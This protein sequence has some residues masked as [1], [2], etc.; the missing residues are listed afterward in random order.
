MK[1]KTSK[2]Q[3]NTPLVRIKRVEIIFVHSKLSASQLGPCY[4]GRK[5]L[6]ANTGGGKA[7]PRAHGEVKF[8]A[9]G[10]NSV[11]DIA[12]LPEPSCL[13]PSANAKLLI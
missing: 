8:A 6:P 12:F 13:Y 10:R 1:A 7:D 2:D 9:H 5:E 3:R 11:S 4:R